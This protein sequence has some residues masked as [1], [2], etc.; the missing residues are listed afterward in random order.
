MFYYSY[1]SN[2]SSCMMKGDIITR[3]Y[4]IFPDVATINQLD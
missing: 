1:T 4:K 3:V 2:F